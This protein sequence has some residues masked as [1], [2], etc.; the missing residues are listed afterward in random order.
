MYAKAAGSRAMATAHRAA[1]RMMRPRPGWPQAYQRARPQRQGGDLRP[2][3]DGSA[4]A[5][6]RRAVPQMMRFRSDCTHVS[7]ASSF[8]VNSHS[9]ARTSVTCAHHPRP[10]SRA[11][12]A[13]PPGC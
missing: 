12:L 7:S 2:L 9:A 11:P 10:P 1:A 8:L 4:R 6:R 13:P 3:A 5:G